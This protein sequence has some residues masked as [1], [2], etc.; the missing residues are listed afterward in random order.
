MLLLLPL[1]LPQPLPQPLLMTINTEPTIKRRVKLQGRVGLEVRVGVR[2]QKIIS[3]QLGSMGMRRE[4]LV[5]V[6]R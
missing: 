4:G 1:S 3:N 2:R 5:E 6:A